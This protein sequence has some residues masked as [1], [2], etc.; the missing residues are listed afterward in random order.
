MGDMKQRQMPYGM[1]VQNIKEFLVKHGYDPQEIDVEAH[2]DPTLSLGEN[3]KEFAR[4]LKISTTQTG[5]SGRVRATSGKEWGRAAKREVDT[6]YCD[7][8]ADNC[9]GHCNNGA[10]RVF[11]KS[12]CSGTVEPCKPTRSAKTA[13]RSS[14]TSKGECTVKGYCVESHVRPPQH[15]TRSGSQIQVRRYCVPSHTRLCRR[16]GYE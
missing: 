14:R 12:G 2:I 4:L 13:R 3:K 5:S 15:N 10:C 1:Q 16:S 7:W 9:E 11:V 8:L 6:Q